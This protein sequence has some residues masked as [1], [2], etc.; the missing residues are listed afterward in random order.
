M[1]LEWATT[2]A[3]TPPSVRGFVLPAAQL[4]GRGLLGPGYVWVRQYPTDTGYAV[5]LT[6][7]R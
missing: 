2:D 3:P 4:V 1:R 5:T 6:V 7:S